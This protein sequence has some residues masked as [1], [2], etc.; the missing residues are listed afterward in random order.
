MRRIDLTYRLIKVGGKA[1]SVAICAM[2]GLMIAGSA[3][4][5]TTLTTTAGTTF[6]SSTVTYV[7]NGVVVAGNG[8][9][10]GIND[11]G[12]S[13]ASR[14]STVTNGTYGS[15]GVVNG[16]A[17]NTNYVLNSGVTV[18]DQTTGSNASVSTTSKTYNYTETMDSLSGSG[19]V[20]PNPDMNIL[21]NKYAGSSDGLF[22]DGTATFSTGA[23]LNAGVDYYYANSNGS[24]MGTGLDSVA[25]VDE[26]FHDHLDSIDGSAT[27]SAGSAAGVAGYAINTTGTVTI[28]KEAPAPGTPQL[29]FNSTAGASGAPVN[30]D[31][32]LYV[33][34]AQG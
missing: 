18:L 10:Y 28:S 19:I 21:S 24:L 29:V 31:G 9:V 12:I 33:W 20:N 3:M 14:S 11:A 6:Y 17:G 32:V 13:S 25:P 5:D 23:R 4:A 27:F 8:T 15:L 34:S 2:T 22:N 16:Y 26:R 1:V 30:A 7:N